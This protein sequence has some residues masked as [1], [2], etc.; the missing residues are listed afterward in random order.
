MDDAGGDVETLPT[1]SGMS[2]VRDQLVVPLGEPERARASVAVLVRAALAGAEGRQVLQTEAV[3]GLVTTRRWQGEAATAYR[4]RCRPLALRLTE[5]DQACSAAAEALSRWV[6]AAGPARAVMVSTR[7]EVLAALPTTPMG[8]VAL[9]DG[10]LASAVAA[11]GAARRDYDRATT[12]AAQALWSAREAVADRTLTVGD[13]V[14]GF[15]GSLWQNVVTDPA[16][17]AWQQAVAVWGVSGE[18]LVDQNAWRGN[19]EAVP[20]EVRARWRTV[21]QVLA[22]PWPVAVAVGGAMVGRPDYERG[23]WG[24]GSGTLAAMAV[25]LPKGGRLTKAL[26]AAAATRV[27]RPPTVAPQLQ[28]VDGLLTKVDLSTNE[29]AGH[30]LERHVTADDAFLVDRMENGTVMSDG[31]RGYQPP[32]AS[33]FHDEAT[34]QRVIDQV[35]HEN[36]A[37]IRTWAAGTD[38]A[39]PLVRDFGS[40]S[41]GTVCRLEGGEPT[42]REGTVAK[43]WLA[44]TA[45]GQIYLDTAYVDVAKSAGTGAR[46]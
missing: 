15:F 19:V 14:Q 7:D 36:E 43:V 41:L 38:P 34:A 18:G 32:S 4:E 10:R 11:F 2:G 31:T 33:R 9:T 23:H 17:D 39:F 6:A 21:E 29:R 1:V 8:P 20:G 3:E 22:D 28:T 46:R 24:S 40:E 5:L 13:Q 37:A 44:R 12:A 27:G 45:D 30:T 16:A 26:E 42:F 25:P 35:L